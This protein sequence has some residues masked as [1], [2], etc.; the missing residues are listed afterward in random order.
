[1]QK[2]YHSFQY[3]RSMSEME[4]MQQNIKPLLLYVSLKPTNARPTHIKV[5]IKGSKH[6]FVFHLHLILKREIGV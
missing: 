4:M 5:K 3:N 2:D 1:M 6:Q